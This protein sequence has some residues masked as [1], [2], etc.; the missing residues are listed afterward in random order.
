METNRSLRTVVDQYH[1]TK[2]TFSVDGEPKVVGR[3][4]DISDFGFCITIK[5]M[6]SEFEIGDRGLLSLERGGKVIKMPVT[7]KWIDSPNSTL[8][9]MGFM[10]KYNLIFSEL[11][12][13]IK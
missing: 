11:A 3:L 9:C 5:E 13:Y 4:L 7:L 10:S 2:V 1:F 6:I 12:P 8:R